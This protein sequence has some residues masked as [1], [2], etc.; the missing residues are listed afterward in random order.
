MST[1]IYISVVIPTFKRPDLLRR[2]LEAIKNQSF[3]KHCFEVIVVADGP[4]RLSAQ[5][6]EEMRLAS[7]EL[8]LNYYELPYKKGPAAAR[9][10][11]WKQ[12]KG[13]LIAFTD[14]DCIPSENW[15]NNYWNAYQTSE[16]EK[17]S[18]TGKVIVPVPERPT[19]YQK[20]VSHLSTADFITANCACSRPALELVRGFDEEFPAA[21]REDSAL[22][23]ELLKHEVPIV[24]LRN[25]EVTHPVRK[26]PWGISIQE[27]K[28]S[29]F[30]ALLFK[31]YPDFYRKK[32]ASQPVWSYYFIIILSLMS[33]LFFVFE[34]QTAGYISLGLWLIIMAGFVY[35]RL[36]GTDISFSH[37]MEMILTSL[38]IP[39]LS[40]FW[41]LRGAIRYK[42]FFL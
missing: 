30:N 5:A 19:D 27:Q 40:V 1:V 4:D 26:A 14:D 31:K 21:W 12:S 36:K 42:V 3:V 39:Y 16:K 23:F 17:I 37:R 2:C 7:R 10:F 13:I 38:L 34:F 18:F 33:V 11:G 41:T 15:L 32:I 22:E 25:A 28:K 8:Q 35:K 6:V 9:N 24:K 20:N 29:M